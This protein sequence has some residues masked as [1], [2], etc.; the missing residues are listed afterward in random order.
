MT[1]VEETILN[2]QIKLASLLSKIFDELYTGNST[3]LTKNYIRK[4]AK[5]I[6]TYTE[7]II[8]SEEINEGDV[9]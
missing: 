9:K 4:Q 8:K 3:A 5:E 6:K 1:K 7:N 2:N